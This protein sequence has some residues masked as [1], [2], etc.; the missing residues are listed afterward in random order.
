MEQEGFTLFDVHDPRRRWCIAGT[1]RN[2]GDV[3]K[4]NYFTTGRD[5]GLGTCVVLFCECVSSGL[6]ENNPVS[7]FQV[8]VF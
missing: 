6:P 3:D 1:K 2:G 5:S 7:L 8:V 4:V